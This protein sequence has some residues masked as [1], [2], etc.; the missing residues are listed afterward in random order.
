MS[1]ILLSFSDST[2]YT[3][4][5]GVN[6]TKRFHCAMIGPSVC[7]E[8]IH[9]ATGCHEEGV[10]DRNRSGMLR[11]GSAASIPTRFRSRTPS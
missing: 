10:R 3:G 7:P 1:Q 2:C 8:P 6:T 11:A 5:I 9:T 4:L